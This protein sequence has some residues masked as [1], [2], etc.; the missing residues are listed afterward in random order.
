MD[1][2]DLYELVAGIELLEQIEEDA[3]SPRHVLKAVDP[4]TGK[5]PF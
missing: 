5:L 1:D 4:F 3:L 2:T